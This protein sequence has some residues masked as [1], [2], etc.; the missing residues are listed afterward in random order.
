MV[1]LTLE[2]DEKLIS[3]IIESGALEIEEFFS[4]IETE[5]E[6]GLKTSQIMRI[7]RKE[8]LNHVLQN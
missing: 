5:S 1:F 7:A 6:F 2:L 3:H 4:R 8:I